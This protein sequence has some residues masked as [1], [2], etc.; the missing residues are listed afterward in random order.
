M[1]GGGGGGPLPVPR[2]TLAGPENSGGGRLS[3]FPLVSSLER[4]P[5]AHFAQLCKC[6]AKEAS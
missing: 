5:P 3:S 1:E 6:L 2:R 4:A